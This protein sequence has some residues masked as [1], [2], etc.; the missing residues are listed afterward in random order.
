MITRIILAFGAVVAIVVAAWMGGSVP[1]LQPLIG[2]ALPYVAFAIFLIGFA[3]KV[4]KWAKSPVPFRI[5]TTAGQEFSLPWIKWSKIDNPSTTGGVILR[6]FFEICCFRSLFRNMRTDLR[7]GWLIHHPTKWLWLLA[8]GFHYS[9]L[10]I[11][12]RHLRLFV[13]PVPGFVETLDAVDGMFQIGIP[14]I[15]LTDLFILLCL[16]GLL[17]RRLCLPKMRFMSLVADY[18]PLFLILGIVISGLLMRFVYRVDIT[19]VKAL[20]NGIASFHPV[21]PEGIGSIFFVHI[22]LVSTLLAYFPFSKLMHMGG[23]FMSPTR[24]LANTNRMEYHENPWRKPPK[25]HSYEEY[26]DMYREYMKEAGL[27]LERE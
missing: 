27:P 6:M 11:A 10:I 7:S 18:F 14:P 15:Y 4:I 9:F 20:A 22:A 5:P 25:F 19:A 16:T 13:Q 21:V 8:L 2:V 3:M 24:N 23:V 17:I 26:E 12:L 1:G